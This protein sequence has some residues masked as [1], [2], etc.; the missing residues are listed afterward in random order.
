LIRIFGESANR[1][2]RQQ[3][4]LDFESRP[5]TPEDLAAVEQEVS[6]IFEGAHLLQQERLA[7]T[8]PTSSHDSPSGLLS[9]NVAEQSLAWETQRGLAHEEFSLEV[10]QGAGTLFETN[11]GGQR[12][13][14]GE[15]RSPFEHERDDFNEWYLLA[16]QSGLVTDYEWR[17]SEYWVLAN[18]QWLGFCE[19]LSMFSCAWL[20]RYLGLGDQCKN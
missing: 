2:Q 3:L 18:A 19:M 14:T 6:Q 7:E 5:R 15:E 9:C 4:Q 20:R 11:E 16:T 12:W 17:G 10:D 1:E 8:R 13:E